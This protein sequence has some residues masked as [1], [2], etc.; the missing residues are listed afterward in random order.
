MFSYLACSYHNRVVYFDICDSE[1]YKL[2]S[3]QQHKYRIKLYKRIEKDIKLLLG[4]ILNSY[5]VRDIQ[6]H[7]IIELSPQSFLYYTPQFD[8]EVQQLV[9]HLNDK[10]NVSKKC[11]IVFKI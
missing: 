1:F 8:K 4:D 7:N 11:R 9:S 3:D 6:N 10:Y 2:N 5:G